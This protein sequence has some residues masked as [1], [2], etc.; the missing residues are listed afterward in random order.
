MRLTLLRYLNGVCGLR[1]PGMPRVQLQGCVRDPTCGNYYVPNRR[2]IR[3]R[4]GYSTYPRVCLRCR[5]LACNR[6]N[7]P[8]WS[9]QGYTWRGKR[10]VESDSVTVVVVSK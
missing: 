10:S 4:F 7:Y 1:R 9:Y 8:R 2:I 6:Y 3:F 5:V